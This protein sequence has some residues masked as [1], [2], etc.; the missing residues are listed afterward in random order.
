MLRKPSGEPSLLELSRGA[1]SHRRDLFIA[2]NP[3]EHLAETH[4]GG[5]NL[6]ARHNDAYCRDDHHKA[7]DNAGRELLAEDGHSE[8]YGC[9]GFEGTENGGGGA[10]DILDGPRGATE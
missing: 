5:G 7:K 6:A 4:K 10:A 9:H 8:E 2:R 1:A 3:R